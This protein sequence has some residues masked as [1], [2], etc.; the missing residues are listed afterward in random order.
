MAKFYTSDEIKQEMDALGYISN[1]YLLWEATNIVNSMLSSEG[2]KGQDISAICLA[3][4]PGSGKTEF[5]KVVFKIV[6]KLIL[7]W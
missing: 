1:E 5:A 3:G 4:P 6:D 2:R 7:M